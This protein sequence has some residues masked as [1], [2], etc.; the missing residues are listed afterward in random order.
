MDNALDVDAKESPTFLMQ[1]ALGL[2]FWWRER[3]LAL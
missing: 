3:E 1:R 2:P